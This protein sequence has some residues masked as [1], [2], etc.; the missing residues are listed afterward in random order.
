MEHPEKPEYQDLVVRIT[1]YCARFIT[2]SREYQQE[3]VS[4]INYSSMN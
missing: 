2:M 3:F 1:G 4:R